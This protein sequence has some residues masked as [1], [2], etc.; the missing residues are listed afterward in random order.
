[1]FGPGGSQPIAEYEAADEIERVYH[2]IRQTLRVSGVNLNFRTWARYDA[3]LPVLWDA[4]KANAGTMAF[5]HAADQLR[6]QA[7][8]FASESGR[9]NAKQQAKLGERQ[10]TSN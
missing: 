4:L 10:M 6:L 1:M 7:A 2:E 3:L 8:R 5:E 9:L